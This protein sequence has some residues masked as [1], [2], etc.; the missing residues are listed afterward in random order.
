MEVEQTLR[1]ER[2]LEM[3][4]AEGRT[5]AD[6]WRQ[7]EDGATLAAEF[8]S[9]L[10]E[11][12]DHRRG[13][14]IGTFGVIPSLD[15]HVFRAQVGEVLEPLS[16]GGRGVV[17]VKVQDLELVDPVELE[18]SRDDLRA[19]LTAERAGQLMRSVLNERRRDTVV[20]VNNELLQRFSP[21]SS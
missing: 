20:T 9:A 18:N 16:A 19:R 7:G 10:T 11:T 17:V 12:Q 4:L 5:L 15:D 1:R 13:T 6:R 14:A 21:T 8:D 3:A 2:A